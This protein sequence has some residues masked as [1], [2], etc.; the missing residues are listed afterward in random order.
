MGGQL[1]A[2]PRWRWAAASSIGTSHQRLETRKQDAYGVRLSS[3]ALLAVVSDGAGS[4]AYGGEGASLVCRHLLVAFRHW[5][6]DHNHLPD[7]D[8]V[9]CWIDDL[10]DRLSV[11]AARHELTRRQFAATLVMLVVSNDQFLTLQI[12]D[13]ALVGRKNGE[14]EALCWPENGEFASTTFFVTDDPEVRLHCVSGDLE[15]D[16][17]A[18]F[19]DGLESVALE[20]ATQQPFARFFDPMIKAI[21]E[22]EGN[23]R[24]ARL[25]EALAKYLETPRICERTDDDKTLI[26]ISKR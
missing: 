23:G 2:D 24:L 8:T 16:A 9:R 4:A 10:R 6:L 7:D 14:W 19:S 11:V 12:G 22:A 5:F 20:Q 1:R 15:H 26:L 13:S 3:S 21:D 25:S 17:F 18:L